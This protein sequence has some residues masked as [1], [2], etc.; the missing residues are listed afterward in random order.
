MF[1][2]RKAGGCLSQG[3]TAAKN[4]LGTS[5]STQFRPRFDPVSTPFRPHFDPISTPFR[6]FRGILSAPISSRVPPPTRPNQGGVCTCKTTCLQPM[7]PESQSRSESGF[8]VQLLLRKSVSENSSL[9]VGR[10]LKGSLK[11]SGRHSCPESSAAPRGRLSF[12]GAESLPLS[13]PPV[14]VKDS[15]SVILPKF[16]WEFDLNSQICGGG[17]GLRALTLHRLQ[18]ARGGWMCL[19]RTTHKIITFCPGTCNIELA[20]QTQLESILLSHASRCFRLPSPTA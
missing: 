3:L 1:A 10:T 8:S 17:W 12:L 7:S 16:W 19:L 14:Q 4:C 2:A 9:R 11:A 18:A 20:I 6:P 15:F 5:R 13:T